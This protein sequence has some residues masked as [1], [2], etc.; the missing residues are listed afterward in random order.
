VTT[1]VEIT[2]VEKWQELLNDSAAIAHGLWKRAVVLQET[3][4]TQDGARRLDAQIGDVVVAGR[5]HSGRGRFGRMWADTGAEGVAVTFVMEVST[6][7]R[8]AIACAVAV[9]E[10]ILA[11]MKITNGRLIRKANLGV[12]WPNDIMANGRKIAGVLIE[13]RDDRAYIGIGVNVRQMSWPVELSARAVSLAELGF[14]IDRLAVIDLLM[15]A[16]GSVTRDDDDRLCSRF[17]ELDVL[18]GTTCGFRIGEREVRGRVL[19]VDPM[20]GLAVLTATD[21]EVWLP[22]AT[23]TVIKD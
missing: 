19:R 9:A 6:P 12:K 1:A 14:D 20:R 4:S 10:A 22:A 5:Q 16:L 13:Q 18:T 3:D 8:L 23:T 15:Q 11:S 2:A 7:E 21:G 17:R